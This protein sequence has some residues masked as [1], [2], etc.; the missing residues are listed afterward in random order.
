M[1]PS[2]FSVKSA[3]AAVVYAFLGNVLLLISFLV[4]DK[5]TPGDLWSMIAKDQN[6]PLSIMVSAFV[7]SLG[8]IIAS[9]IHG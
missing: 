1:D 6:L 9:A 5:L 3:I 7:L 2:L 8:I 4:L